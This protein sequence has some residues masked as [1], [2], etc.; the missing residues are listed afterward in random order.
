[1]ALSWSDR[2][3]NWIK[4]TKIS[5]EDARWALDCI[6]KN[7]DSI[8][9]LESRLKNKEDEDIANDLKYIK[10]RIKDLINFKEDNIDDITLNAP[11]SYKLQI[12]IPSTLSYLMKTWA[13]AEGR[14]LS[15]VALQCLET[16][17]REMKSKGSIPPIA[18]DRYYSACEKKV[19]LA[20]I[21]N[22]WD[23][24]ESDLTS[25]HS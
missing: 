14:D 20:E 19:A 21:N 17:L 4:T 1:M 11:N 2:R 9:A 15:S 8:Y 23:D 12:S 18:V 5:N 16:G 3:E 7:E 25:I 6:V 22:L 24:H 13:A 10:K